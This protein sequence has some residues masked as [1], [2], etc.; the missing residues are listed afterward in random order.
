MAGGPALGERSGV[1]GAAIGTIDVSTIAAPTEDYLGVT[2]GT[3]VQAGTGIHRQAGPMGLVFN[4]FECDYELA[5]RKHG[6]G[7]AS[8]FDRQ[9]LAGAVPVPS[10]RPPIPLPAS[11][12]RDPA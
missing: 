8:V 10:A 12:S 2:A 5:V 1:G 9:I 7:M 6:W 11:M 4:Q 3:V